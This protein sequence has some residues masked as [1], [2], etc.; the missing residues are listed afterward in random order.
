MTDDLTLLASA[1]LDGDVTADERAR[2]EDDPIMLVE[3][4]RLRAVRALLG[5]PDAPAISVRETHLA[6]ALDAWER[7]PLA[8]RS[9]A[10]RDQTPDGIDAAAVAGA[11]SVTAPTS[12]NNRRRPASTRWLTG[13]A[14]ALVLVLAGGV[15]LQLNG[16]DDLDDAASSADSESTD[17]AAS[18]V[19]DRQRAGGDLGAD[20]LAPAATAADAAP[21]QL[22]TGV[23]DGAPP[24][25]EGGLPQLLNTTDL[26]DF[27][28]VAVGAPVAPDDAPDTTSA[29]GDLTEAASEL[30]DAEPRC[31]GV[32]I[33]I[34]P[35]VYIDTAVVVGIDQRR[36]LALAYQPITC[37]EVARVRLP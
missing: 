3:V 18:D 2:V 27:A 29:V 4:D 9:G 26:A 8:E 34:G 12:L 10:R 19:A 13:A 36:N 30:A 25:E 11:A 28:G 21:N 24:A 33:V 22:D 1:Y 20:E 32:D 37:T 7:L 23:G 15:A 5:D 14:A 16:S 35:A 31:L 17:L 6:A